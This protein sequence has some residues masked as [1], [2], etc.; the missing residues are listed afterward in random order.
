MLG[1]GV[2]NN[3]P[4]YDIKLS[5]LVAPWNA[6]SASSDVGIFSQALQRQPCSYRF[7]KP[8]PGAN[9]RLPLWEIPADDWPNG[10]PACCADCPTVPDKTKLMPGLHSLD[11][12]SSTISTTGQL[13][14]LD[15]HLLRFVL[16]FFFRFYADSGHSCVLG[17]QVPPLNT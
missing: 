10:N 1:T 11:Q 9:L 17:A 2:R 12:N 14:W 6:D 16:R 13:I 3:V 7:M 5:S 4:I 15:L 8:S